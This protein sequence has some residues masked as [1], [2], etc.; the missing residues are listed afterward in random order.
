MHTHTRQ[1]KNKEKAQFQKKTLRFETILM[2][3]C[4]DF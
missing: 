2:S 3:D 4:D 1:N